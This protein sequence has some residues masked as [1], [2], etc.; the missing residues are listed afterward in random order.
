MTGT[1]IIPRRIYKVP[2]NR[3]TFPQ[4]SQKGHLPQGSRVSITNWSKS[5]TNYLTTHLTNHQCNLISKQLKKSNIFI[6][7]TKNQGS[8][9]IGKIV[10]YTNWI[11]IFVSLLY[12]SRVPSKLNRH[13]GILSGLNKHAFNGGALKAYN[14]VRY[15]PMRVRIWLT[16]AGYNIWC[17]KKYKI[18]MNDWLNVTG[19]V[20]HNWQNFINTLWEKLGPASPNF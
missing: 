19:S 9:Y 20:L 1:P 14:L 16:L 5:N 3:V 10:R 13:R 12:R 15:V 18:M 17:T 4:S 7:G 8:S 2:T 11:C 6:D